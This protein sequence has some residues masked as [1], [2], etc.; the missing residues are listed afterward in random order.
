MDT[1]DATGTHERKTVLMNWSIGRK[2]VF[3]R[4]LARERRN[5][6]A[7]LTGDE[8]FSYSSLVGETLTRITGERPGKLTDTS[9]DVF[10][11]IGLPHGLFGCVESE[12]GECKVSH[13]AVHM[14]LQQYPC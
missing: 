4:L 9:P 10:Y 14:G 6:V 8:K 3:V 11:G 13:E 7:P 2:A 5:E 1:A 12:L